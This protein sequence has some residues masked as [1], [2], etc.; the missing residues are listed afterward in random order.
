MK[1]I[2]D[3]FYAVDEPEDLSPEAMNRFLDRRYGR[4]PG[5]LEWLLLNLLSIPALF[6][7]RD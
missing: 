3:V 1:K 2:A 7:R 5:F 6:R 4:V